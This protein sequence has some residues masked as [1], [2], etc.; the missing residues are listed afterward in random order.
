M[1]DCG[2]GCYIWGRKVSIFVDILV[3]GHSLEEHGN[4]AKRFLCIND[5]TLNTPMSNLFRA[6]WNLVP[7]QHIALPRHLV[8]TE[9]KRLQGVF[10][11]LQTMKIFSIDQQKQQRFLLLDG[12]MLVRTN[13]DDLFQTRV[14][15]AVMRGQADTCLFD[16]RPAHTYFHGYAETSFTREHQP[17]LGGING[18]LVL[19]KPDA[20]VYDDMLVKLQEYRPRTAMAEQEFLSWY[21]AREGEWNAMHKKNNFQIHQMYLSLPTP[22]PGS[23]TPSSFSH[24]VENPNEIRIFHFSANQKPSEI[25]IEHMKSVQGWLELP[26]RLDDHT[27]FMMENHAAR[28]KDIFEHEDWIEKIKKLDVAAHYEWFSAWKRTWRR[29]ISFVVNDVLQNMFSALSDEKFTRF[30]CDACGTCFKIPDVTDQTNI[31]RDHILFNCKEM[32]AGVRIPVKHQMNLRTFFF[33]P[34]GEQVESK[35]IYLSA[36]YKFYWQFR[37]PRVEVKPVIPLLPEV[38]PDIFLPPYNIP[39]G[40]LAISEDLGMDASMVTKCEQIRALRQMQRQYEDAMNI[41]QNADLYEWKKDHASGMTWVETLKT[42][43]TAMKW[44][45]KHRALMDLNDKPLRPGTSAQSTGGSS[46]LMPLQTKAKPPLPGGVPPW[47]AHPT[48]HQNMGAAILSPP[49]PP[50]PRAAASLAPPPPPPPRR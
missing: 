23:S 12:D 16:Q 30:K 35:L 48:Q 19:F 10:S 21:W 46:H 4:K 26:A 15:A 20:E 6:F 24:M 29:L 1:K 27:A 25:L 33:V 5:D 34:C 32:A 3:L 44:L 43:F 9:Q 39:K 7:V 17:M 28:N 11:K 49:P 42:A 2:V 18:G 8:G 37:R 14:P 45:K 41:A 22:P 36:V 31:L 13:I 47:R 38:Q 50:P 40:I